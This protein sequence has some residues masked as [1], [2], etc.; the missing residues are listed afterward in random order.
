MGLQCNVNV[1]YKKWKETHPH[2]GEDYVMVNKRI[3][4]I[5]GHTVPKIALWEL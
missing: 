1:P 5:M 3:N 2:Q 4:H